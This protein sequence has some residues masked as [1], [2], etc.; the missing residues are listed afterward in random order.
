M[1]ARCA[2]RR[3][4]PSLR[5]DL[6]DVEELSARAEAGDAPLFEA[7][8]GV[9]VA[10]EELF[11]LAV[12]PSDAH[13]LRCG[14]SIILRGRDAPV[15]DGHVAVNCPGRADRHR[16]FLRRRSAPPPGVQLGPQPAPPPEAECVRPGLLPKPSSSAGP[17][18]RRFLF[19]G[20]GTGS[21]IVYKSVMPD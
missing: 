5:E 16:R 3:S 19:G 2:V 21:A 4:A 13:R 12:T 20:H 7:L 1:S 17:V 15:L 9:D 6:I 18:G 14:Q 11:Q 8:E 10:L